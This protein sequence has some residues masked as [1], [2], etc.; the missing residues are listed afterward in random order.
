[1]SSMV[2]S[3]SALQDS[4]VV[5]RGRFALIGLATVVASVLA[6]VVFYYLAGTVVDYHPDF[7][8][9][10]NAGGT[11]FFTIFFAIG[12]VLVYAGLLRWACNPARIFTIISAV[13]LA[14][15]IV[16]DVT[17]IPSTEGA[18]NGQTTVLILLHFVAAAVIVWM[19]TNLTR[20]QAR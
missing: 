20:S 2:M 11:L 9:L 4:R 19:L 18:S 16:P 6:N 1:M 8:P 17:I 5:N 7:P 15:S 13:V 10:A 14:L 3:A 12:A